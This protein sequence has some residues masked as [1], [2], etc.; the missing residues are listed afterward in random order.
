MEQTKEVSLEQL[1]EWKTRFQK[2][3]VQIKDDLDVYSLAI[4][5]IDR[6]LQSTTEEGKP[7]EKNA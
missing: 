5:S 2:R 7:D 3:M 1:T 6:D 4:R